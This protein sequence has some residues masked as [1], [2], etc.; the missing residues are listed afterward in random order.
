M[1][2]YGIFILGIVSIAV[3]IVLRRG[4]GGKKMEK[5]LTIL[6]IEKVQEKSAPRKTIQELFELYPA[7]YIEE[8]EIDWGKPEGDE[9]W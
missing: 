8:E 5:T 4:K 2:K 9:V 3:A 6:K 1:P 7:D